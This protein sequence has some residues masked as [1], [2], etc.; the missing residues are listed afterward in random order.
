[1]ESVFPAI[2]G[3]IPRVFLLIIAVL[4]VRGLFILIRAP[5][6]MLPLLW[7]IVLVAMAVPATFSTSLY[8]DIVGSFAR[9]LTDGAEAGD[10]RVVFKTG[11]LPRTTNENIRNSSVETGNN[12]IKSEETDLDSTANESNRISVFG[13]AVFSIWIIGFALIVTYVVVSLFRLGR[14]L[15]D[16]SIISDKGIVVYEAKGIDTAFVLGLI[17]PA[18]YIPSGISLEV[19]DKIIAH[20]M[21]HIRRADP[22][23]KLMCFLLCGV[24]WFVL[25]VWLVY[26]FLSVDI[27]AACDEAVI[28]DQDEDYRRSYATALLALSTS[29]IGA[30][31]P[32]AFSEGNPK[33]R[34]EDIMEFKKKNIVVT[35]LCGVILVGVVFVGITSPRASAEDLAVDVPTSEKSESNYEFLTL[36]M[37]RTMDG[38]TLIADMDKRGMKRVEGDDDA[39]L[40]DFAER[41]ILQP[42]RDASDD[43][44]AIDHIGTL[45]MTSSNQYDYLR[46]ANFEDILVRDMPQYTVSYFNKRCNNENTGGIRYTGEYEI[47]PKDICDVIKKADFDLL[48]WYLYDVNSGK[49]TVLSKDDPL[50]IAATEDFYSFFAVNN[51]GD[52][53]DFT[54]IVA[55]IMGE[56]VEKS[57]TTDESSDTDVHYYF[58][59]EDEENNADTSHENDTNSDIS[60][61]YLPSEEIDTDQNVIIATDGNTE[62]DIYYVYD[63]DE[64]DETINNSSDQT[65]DYLPSETIVTT[66]GDGNV[67]LFIVY[68]HPSA[69]TAEWMGQIDNNDQE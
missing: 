19:R 37:L 35:L 59:D 53:L 64:R 6:R 58:Y 17:R 14:R 21:M 26:Y 28:R 67:S 29:G 32:P 12:M 33:R 20:E 41:Y 48:Y 46:F 45:I 54:N 47:G 4:L 25:P 1:M 40:S 15:R 30:F 7:I 51:D 62:E 10:V 36:D 57:Y 55:S 50:K 68:S 22:I 49:Y 43:M 34:I 65:T 18:V 69:S 42:V 24:Y 61:E 60:E 52:I 3:N 13:I 11:V 31:A 44:E 39:F 9:Q 2:L 56:E 66:T 5:K 23:L 63:A 27:E 38:E 16:R 8:P